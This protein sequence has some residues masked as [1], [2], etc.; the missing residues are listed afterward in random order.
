VVQLTVC[1]LFIFIQEF[2]FIYH[3]I[4]FNAVT[5]IK[6]QRTASKKEAPQSLGKYL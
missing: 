3:C 6:E 4:I 5:Y 1:A 2:M